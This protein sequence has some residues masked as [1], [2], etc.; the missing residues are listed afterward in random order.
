MVTRVRVLSRWLPG[1]KIVGEREKE[2]TGG[3]RV[4]TGKEKQ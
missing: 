2:R 3:Q 4:R 1:K